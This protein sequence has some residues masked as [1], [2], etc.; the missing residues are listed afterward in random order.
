MRAA[1]RAAGQVVGGA[2]TE[3]VEDEFEQEEDVIAASTPTERIIPAGA[4]AV[5]ISSNA[6]GIG[7]RW[8]TFQDRLRERRKQ[9]IDGCTICTDERKDSLTE[10]GLAPSRHGLGILATASAPSRAR[11]ITK[12]SGFVFKEQCVILCARIC[13]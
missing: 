1:R 13:L 5:I 11:S 9:T 12:A 8:D 2:P 7:P 4:D 10:S 3:G 6:S